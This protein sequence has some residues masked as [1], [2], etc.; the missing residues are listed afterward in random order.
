MIIPCKGKKAG[1]HRQYNPNKPNK[2]GFKNLV[3]AGVSGIIYD[4][5][6]YAE[7]ITFRGI[8][9]SKEEE[10]LGVGNKIVIALCKTVKNKGSV[11]YFD[12][13]FTSM[14]LIYLLR[15]EYGIFCLGTIRQ[16]RLKDASKKLL[17]DKSQKKKGRGTFSQVVCNKNKLS[18]VKWFNNK[19]VTLVSSYVDAYLLEKIKRF[20]K[21]NRGCNLSSD[22]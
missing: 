20:S 11:V 13:Y 21:K 8:R 17:T 18:V 1:S 16:N 14:E 5:L 19:Q 10:S 22:R 2:W 7:D 6:L 15:E 4:F 12:N 3:R 9:F